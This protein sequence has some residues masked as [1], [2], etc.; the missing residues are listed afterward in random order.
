MAINLGAAYVDIVP[1]TSGLARNLKRDIETPLAQSGVSSGR[2]FASS[3]TSGLSS[4]AGAVGR[5]VGA[6]V[7]AT[8]TA[9]GIGLGVALTGGWK[10][11]T[12]IDDATRALTISLGDAGKATS[13][14]DDVLSVVEGTPFNLDHFAAA[15]QQMAGMGI[16]ADKIPVYLTAIGEA[17]ATQGSRANEYAERLST[18][19][20]QVA[21]Q[22]S[23]GMMEV[24]RLSDVG[25]NAL[26]IL[27]N[28]FGLTT[29]EMK[30][31]ISTGAV[32][33][34]EA[35]DVL[36]A[37]I[38]DGSDGVAGATVA[39]EGTM[40]SLRE[41]LSGA[42][43]GFKAS[44]DRFGV[45]ILEPFKDDITEFITVLT[46]MTDGI[47]GEVKKWAEEFR[48]TEGFQNFMEWL[49]GLPEKLKGVAG[50]FEGMSTVIGP[51]AGAFAALATSGLSALPFLGA[52]F[53]TISPLVGAFAG[54]V[55]VS[56]E[57]QQV[58]KDLWKAL[59][60]VFVELGDAFAEMAKKF[61][62]RFVDLLVRLADVFLD[63]L[64]ALLPALPVLAQVL[65][66]LLEFV[67]IPG[68]EWFVTGLEA[69]AS[70]FEA[71]GDW[72]PAAATGLTLAAVGMWALNAA[73]AANPIMW[74]VVG[75]I[76][77]VGALITAYQEVEWFRDAVDS[78]EVGS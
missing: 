2:G 24:R 15:A 34:G 8:A 35:L 73:M 5:T 76:T 30:K 63:V 50:M 12:T 18:V 25:V 60:P 78:V 44:L 74:V 61:T 10:R 39:L 26:A 13:L 48:K 41:S 17:A 53:P 45:A 28:H 69:I 70:G 64:E 33:A 21:A 37:G 7:T 3:F 6:A 14:L 52:L 31:M 1:S 49:R 62:P 36:A 43:G 27:G 77:L 19:F 11:M 68:L 22:G 51:L 57:L 66:I 20:S 75:L 72:G 55:A 59:E 38:L 4:L 65:D 9:A 16:E 67:V 71:M 47:A 46:E 40:A 54:L 56:P 29:E 42:A 32:P 23:I 58:F